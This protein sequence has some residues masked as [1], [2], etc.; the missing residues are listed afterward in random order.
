MNLSLNGTLVHKLKV[1]KGTSKS[2]S[3]WQKQT[4]VIDSGDEY[5]P[6]VAFSCFGEDRVKALKEFKKGDQIEV[7]FNL[8]SR[9]YNGKYYTNAEAWKINKLEPV[10][11][12]HQE[13]ENQ[14][15]PF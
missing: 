10:D 15:L 12:V 4:I 14:D 3:E 1:E 2:G 11:A 13:D 5:N 8:K 6:E 9:E 7:L